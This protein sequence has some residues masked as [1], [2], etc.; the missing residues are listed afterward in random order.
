M[1]VTTEIAVFFVGVVI[2]NLAGLIRIYVSM[3]VSEAVLSVKVD[4]LINDV[5]A[6]GGM[7]RKLKQEKEDEKLAGSLPE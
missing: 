6:L 2:A 1:Q 5:N 4:R 7:V 3:R